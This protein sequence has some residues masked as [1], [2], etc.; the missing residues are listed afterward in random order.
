MTE[1]LLEKLRFPTLLKLDVG[2]NI[3]DTNVSSF[4]GRTAHISYLE[5]SAFIN[6]L[7][8]RYEHL[9]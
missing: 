2:F 5:N 9:F 7:V 1:N 3:K 4:I 6:M 8:Y